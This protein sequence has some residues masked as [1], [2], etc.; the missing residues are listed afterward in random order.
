MLTWHASKS[1]CGTGISHSDVLHHY[2]LSIL[3]FHFSTLPHVL[4]LCQMSPADLTYYGAHSFTALPRSTLLCYYHPKCYQLPGVCQ[5]LYLVVN[6]GCMLTMCF[7]VKPVG[8]SCFTKFL[9]T[10]VGEKADQ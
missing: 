10:C 8:S 1:Q 9:F 3:V 4:P 2:L 6:V 7:K 5:C